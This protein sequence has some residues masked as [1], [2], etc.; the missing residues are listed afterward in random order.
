VPSAAQGPEAEEKTIAGAIR[1]D[2]ILSAEIM[3]ISLKA[4]EGDPSWQFVAAIM[5]VIA[6]LI[7]VVVYGAVALIVK[8]DDIGLALARRD[9]EA[10]QRTG[11][12]LVAAMPK[13]LTFLTVVG[14][15][16]MLWVGGHIILAGLKDLHVWD[17]PYN[18]VTKDVRG[19]FK[20]IPGVGGLFAWLADTALSAILG[21]AVGAVIV[22]VVETLPFMKKDDH[23][24]HADHSHAAEVA[25]EHE[26]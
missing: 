3:V 21:L 11:K 18:F 13:V 4:I 5:V 20:D 8:M 2:F 12:M 16:A 17:S 7:T 15:A 23:D 24:A 14:T 26:A 1:T 6:I 10:S 25:D 9:D 22:K 19:V